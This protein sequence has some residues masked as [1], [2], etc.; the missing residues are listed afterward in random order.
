MSGGLVERDVELASLF[1]LVDA[2]G[3]GR[4]GSANL[5]GPA[6]V[7]KTAVARALGEYAAARGVRVWPSSA[8]LLETRV[9]F[10]VMRR[11]LDAP[12]RELSAQ[13][14]AEYGSSPARLA[15]TQLWDHGAAAAR[16]GAAP[17]QGD[18]LHSLGWLLT[19]LVRDQPAVLVVDDAQWADEES[20]LFLGSLRERLT[21]LPIAVL[22]AARD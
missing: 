19:E 7:G 21:E 14:R 12:V 6:G 10:G 17:A 16:A 18:M 11:L 22:V 4:G 20:L 1:A 9:P 15:L 2:A 3:S 13:R 8:G 5:V